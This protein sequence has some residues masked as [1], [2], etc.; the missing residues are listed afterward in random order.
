MKTHTYTTIGMV[1]GALVAGLVV[2]A[3]ATAAVPGPAAQS[4]LR[5]DI[6]ESEGISGGQFVDSRQDGRTLVLDP[7]S[8]FHYLRHVGVD[9]PHVALNFTFTDPTT[10]F[11]WYQQSLTTQ[12]SGAFFSE[13]LDLN[14]LLIKG[15][16]LIVTVQDASGQPRICPTAI[17]YAVMLAL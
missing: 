11:Q 16:P 14:P 8:E 12:S 9:G 7:N 1:L 10:G 15:G 3:P 13:P 6:V 5:A 17:E 2:A 4:W